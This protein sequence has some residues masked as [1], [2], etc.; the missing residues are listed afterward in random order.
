MAEWTASPMHEIIIPSQ[1]HTK[2]VLELI[3]ASILS[4]SQSLPAQ[5]TRNPLLQLRF[6]NSGIVTSDMDFRYFHQ[7][8]DYLETVDLW[9]IQSDATYLYQADG[10]KR[11]SPPD[12]MR[13]AVPL[14]GLGSGTVELRADGSL[15]D[16]NIFNNSPAYGEKV[17]LEKALFGIRTFQK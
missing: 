17:Q 6:E 7:P 10:D 14:G 15:Q 3:I 2:C 16:W 5:S 11:G 8:D 12:G 9:N 13:S 1:L 4:L